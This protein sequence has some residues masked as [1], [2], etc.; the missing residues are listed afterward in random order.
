MNIELL[1][2]Q[3]LA[4]ESMYAHARTLEGGYRLLS[5]IRIKKDELSFAQRVSK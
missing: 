5:L 4:I 2:L 1:K 3:L